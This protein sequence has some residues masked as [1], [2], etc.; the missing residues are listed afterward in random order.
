M[1]TRQTPRTIPD[2]PNYWLLELGEQGIHGFRDPLPVYKGLLGT[3]LQAV[4]F[5]GMVAAARDGKLKPEMVDVWL[6]T[7]A[8]A[9]CC[10]FDFARDLDTPPL[11]TFHGDVMAYGE[12]VLYELQDAGYGDGDLSSV[13]SEFLKRALPVKEIVEEAKARVDFTEATAAPSS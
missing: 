4:D 6:V 11:R 12:A 5:S 1:H 8:V 7:G 3:A 9:G 13:L 2:K 10:W